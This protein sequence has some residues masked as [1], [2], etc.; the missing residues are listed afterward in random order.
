MFA[1]VGDR[2]IY[3]E[4]RGNEEGPTLVMLRGLARNA[5]HWGPVLERLERRFYLLLLDNR[6]FG[7]S[8]SSR[9]PY[10]VP[11]LADDVIAV[12]DAANVSRAHVLGSSLGGMI[13]MR[14]AI[15]HGGRLDRLVLVS[16]TAG[17]RTASPP[18]LR[19]FA[20]MARARLRPLR[21]S[22]AIDARYVLGASY[23]TEHPEVVDGW[24]DLARRYPVDP[25]ALVYQAVA[26]RLHDASGELG[27]IRAPTLVLT[28]REDHL[29]PPDNS[30]R[31]ARGIAGAEL[32]TLDGDSHELLQT[33]L[34]PAL[35]H[36]E[37]FLSR[38]LGAR[39]VTTRA[40]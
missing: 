20:A 17:G 40:S 8:D 14:F 9:Y 2:R 38:P 39:R 23:A 24:Y 28:C 7:R 30:E 1:N 37:E 33:H 15:D 5:L 36:V 10:L 6:G 4:L 18:R 13:A 26:A 11:H 32:V 12:M 22:L 16:T 35:E 3:F 29:V 19:S 27:E 25:R 31:L 21:E 34:E